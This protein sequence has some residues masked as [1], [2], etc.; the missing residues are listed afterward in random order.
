[1]GI[2]LMYTFQLFYNTT[3]PF[4]YAN[5]L[6]TPSYVKTCSPCNINS[7]FTLFFVSVVPKNPYRCFKFYRDNINT[8]I[9]RVMCIHAP[10]IPK[11]L[12]IS[13]IYGVISMEIFTQSFYSTIPIVPYVCM[14][15]CYILFTFVL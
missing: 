4:F 8:L 11:W 15:V 5:N 7:A 2:P 14:R 1:M 13:F 10:Y 9:N 12:I 6:S 3:Y